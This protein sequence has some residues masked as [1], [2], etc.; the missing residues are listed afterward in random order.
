MTRAL[1]SAALAPPGGKP[2]PGACAWVCCPRDAV[3]AVR[4]WPYCAHHLPYAR[5]YDAH[6]PGGAPPWLGPA[7]L[8]PGEWSE[9]DTRKR[10]HVIRHLLRILALVEAIGPDGYRAEFRRRPYRLEAR[11]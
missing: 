5:I 6:Y 8:A 3:G 9:A 7:I 10:A 1:L 4:Q 11:W 2:K